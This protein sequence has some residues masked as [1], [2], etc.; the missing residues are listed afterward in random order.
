MTGLEASKL[1]TATWGK[2][3]GT[4]VPR[5]PNTTFT[6]EYTLSYRG[7]LIMMQGIFIS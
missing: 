6:K 7:L 3:L 1:R 5:E 2:W 4:C